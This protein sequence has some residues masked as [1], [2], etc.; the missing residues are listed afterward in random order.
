[1]KIEKDVAFACFELVKGYISK[2]DSQRFMTLKAAKERCA[3]LNKDK[4]NNYVVLANSGWH[5]PIEEGD[6]K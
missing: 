2:Q 3:E 4:N 5:E 6:I 1:M